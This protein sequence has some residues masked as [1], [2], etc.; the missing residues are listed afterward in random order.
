MQDGVDGVDGLDGAQSVTL[1]A[2]GKHA[3]VAGFFDDAVSWFERNASTGALTYHTENQSTY[4][5]AEEDLGAVI[6]VVASYL[7]AG[8]ADENVSSAGTNPVIPWNDPPTDLNATAPLI[9]LENQAVGAVVGEFNASDPDG[10][11]TLI[12]TLVDE[13]NQTDNSLFTLDANGTLSA[14]ASFDRETLDTYAVR[15][16]VTDPYG[17][18]MEQSF[19]VTVGDVNE[20]P[21]ISRSGDLEVAVDEDSHPVSWP[22]EIPAVELNATD[23]DGDLLTWS[24]L[25]APANGTAT[26]SGSGPSPEVLN[27]LPNPDFNGSDSFVVEVSDGALS[28]QVTVSIRVNARPENQW[29]PMVKEVT[30]SMW[31]ELGSDFLFTGGGYEDAPDP[32]LTLLEGTRYV[33]EPQIGGLT[34][35]VGTAVGVPY[36][37]EEVEENPTGMP[38]GTVIL[39]PDRETPRDLVYYVE[40]EAEMQGTIRVI[41]GRE[42]KFV[43]PGQN[44]LQGFGRGMD[45]YGNQLAVGSV[46]DENWMGSVH[47]FE[48]DANGS[49]QGVTEIQPQ[50]RTNFGYFGWTIAHA[51]SVLLV[52][53]PSFTNAVD[54]PGQAHVFEQV[55][56]V[57]TETLSLSPSISSASDRFGYGVDASP[58][59]LVVGGPRSDANGL[60]NG[61]AVFIH[62]R[63]SNGSWG[64]EELLVPGDLTDW[65]RFGQSVSLDGDRLLVGAPR[66]PMILEMTPGLPIC[67]TRWGSNGCRRPSFLP[68]TAT[69]RKT[70]SGNR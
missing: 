37:G 11:V 70:V 14:N 25:T 4:T 66:E 23:V 31:P 18:W 35:R 57:W 43:R 26:V 27:Y 48:K 9:I 47:L 3:Y 10:P 46:G 62:D 49:W 24:V 20:A 69:K 45:A 32:A 67:L 56:G 17:E 50:T 2:D 41:A 64:A 65:D 19:T 52:G 39:K 22:E 54:I 13:N 44:K 15:V 30:Y 36:V 33:F 42:Q 55:G 8:G 53:A 28:D 7:D 51:G 34:L 29:I 61:G 38:L 1:S 5:V 21:V 6:T 59:R 68:G 63:E 40:E 58:N 60:T 12:Y 16:R